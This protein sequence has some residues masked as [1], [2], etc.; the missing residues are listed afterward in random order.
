MLKPKWVGNAKNIIG[1]RNGTND[2]LTKMAFE[3]TRELEAA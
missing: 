3:E 2:V 1:L